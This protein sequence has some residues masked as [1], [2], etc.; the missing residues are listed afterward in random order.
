VLSLVSANRIPPTV[1]L[2]GGLKLAGKWMS[3]VSEAA[4]RRYDLNATCSVWRT[5][6]QLE[7]PSAGIDRNMAKLAY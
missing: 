1:N 4:V 5:A 7:S 3:A 6:M 2:A